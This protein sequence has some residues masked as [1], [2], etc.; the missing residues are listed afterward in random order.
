MKPDLKDWL[1]SIN[2]SKTNLIDED[3]DVEKD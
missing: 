3:P 2:L 1:N